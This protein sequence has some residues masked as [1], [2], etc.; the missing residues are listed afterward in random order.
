MTRQLFFILSYCLVILMAASAIAFEGPLQVRNLYPIFLHADEPYLEKASWEDSFSLGIAHASTYTVQESGDWIIHLDMETTELAL[1][2][3]RVLS[4]FLELGI[5][6]PVLIT[7]G[8]FLDGFI[9]DFHDTFGFDDYGRSA[10]PHNDFLYEVRKDGELIVE[11]RSRVSLGDVR[12]A[13]KKPF[14]QN[15]RLTAGVTANMEIPLGDA[16]QGF[17]NGGLDAGFALVLDAQITEWLMNYWNAG[18]VFPAD[19]RGHTSLNLRNFVYGGVCLEA[20]VS[21]GFSL[22]VQLQGQSPVYPQT[23]LLAVDR[24]SYLLAFG[25][26]YQANSR[27]VEVSL[28]EDVNTAGA[29]DFIINVTYKMHI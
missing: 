3:K 10:R 26:R 9:E 16:G 13:V 24:G 23:D 22:L 27:S 1:R 29:P 6:I 4:D 8:G 2:Y 19:V 14:F 15:E 5:D 7:G 18:V 21:S 25:G 11:G 12:L 28:T 20:M 17:G